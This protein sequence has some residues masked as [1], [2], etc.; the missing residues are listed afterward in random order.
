MG[1][2]LALAW[3]ASGPDLEVPPGGQESHSP[4]LGCSELVCSSR[5]F[6]VE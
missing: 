3:T 5:A 1:T 2:P 6:T 4:P